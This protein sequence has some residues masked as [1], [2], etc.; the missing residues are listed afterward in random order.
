MEPDAAH[1]TL[2]GTGLVPGQVRRYLF[3]HDFHKLSMGMVRLRKWWKAVL[4]VGL[5]MVLLQ[6]AVSLVARTHRVHTYLTSQLTRAFGRP[7]E[8][9]R[10]NARILPSPQLSADAVTIGEDPAFGYEYFLRADRLSAGL[11]WGGLLRGHFEFGTLSL[12]RPN[13]ILVRGFEDHWNLERWLPS[14]KTN[15]T[16]GARVYGPPAPVAPVNRLERLEFDD[17]RISFKRGEEKLPFAFTGVSGSVEQVSP[18]RWQLQLEAQPWRSGVLLQSAGTLRVRGDVAGTS[19]RLQPAEISVQWTE[20]SLADVLRLFQGQDYGVRGLFTLDVTAKISGAEAGTPGDWTYSVLARASRV[21]RWDLTERPDNPALNAKCKGRWNPGMG[22]LL[23][24]EIGLEGPRSNLRGMLRYTRSSTPSLELR[25]DSMGIQASDLLAWYRA[26]HPD[27]AEGLAAEQYFTGGMML[28]GWP[29]ALE[30]AALSSNG[31]TVNIPGFAQPVRIGPLKG[32][33]E[34]SRVVIGP[35]RV[36]LGD[37]PRDMDAAKKRR[38]PAALENSVLLTISQ[39]LNTRSGELGLEGRIAKVEDFLRLSAAL[40][41]PLNHGWELTGQAT[42]STKWEWADPFRGHWNGQV[43]FSNASLAVAGLNQPVKI[44]EGALEWIAGRHIARLLKVDAFGGT[45]TGDI[46]ETPGAGPDAK[47]QWGF[48]LTV[49]QLNAADLDRW[50]GP[51]ARPNWVQHLLRSVFGEVTPSTPASEL[52]RRVNA[53]GELRIAHLTI[54]KLK[55]DDVSAKGS[56]HDLKLDVRESDALWAGGKVRAK[57]EASF[58]PRPRYEISADLDR[59]N[60]SQLPGTGRMAVH[61]AGGASGSLQLKTNGVGREELLQNLEGQALVQLKKVEL[62]G[63][64]VPASV[65]AGAPRSGISRWPGGECAFLVRNRSLVLQWLHLNSG[66]EQTA[67]EGSLSF[68][69]NADLR[70]TTEALEKTSAK[71]QKSAGKRRFLKISGSID[72]PHLTVEQ[73]PEPQLVN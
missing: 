40:G 11:R 37:V 73:S 1:R 72:A 26:F 9:G 14:S 12:T 51:R 47:A 21:H 39:D 8:V 64:D 2:T 53:Q 67:V 20:A 41:R 33:R 49:D 42:A 57:I 15:P 46:E 23:A 59:V 54:E 65:A 7:V 32:G 5:F 25:L 38:V 52:L 44:S 10:F 22:T 50:I 35:V 4:I 69:S 13:L 16:P 34:R 30:S 18:G 70:V 66:R 62:R 68:A 17:G 31:G 45:W 24:E 60:L 43:A 63:W 36:S 28:R 3:L 71:S 29:L 48:G 58:L 56:L 55:L 61:V 19:T 27:V 6:V